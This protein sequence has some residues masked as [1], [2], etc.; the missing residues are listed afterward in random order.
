MPKHHNII[1]VGAGLSGLYTAWKLQQT[2]QDVIVLEARSRSG[3]RIFSVE[4]GDSQFDLGPAWV[5]PQMQLR[6][7]QLITELKLEVFKQFT[8][9]DMLY[10]KNITQVERYAAQSSHSESYRV[11]G[12]NQLLTSAIK[13][14]L[15]ASSLCL[16][17]RVTSINSEDIHV[18]VLQNNK[19]AVYTANRVI[20][21]LPP[22]VFQQDIT[23]TPE[24]SDATTALWKNTPTWM[25]THSKIIFIYDKPFWRE[26]N[27]SGEVFSHVGPLA[28]IYDASP[29][30][31]KLY[32]LSAFVGLNPHQRKH[33]DNDQ[34]IASCLA[35]LKRVFGEA[36]QPP[37]EIQLKD[38]SSEEFTC[39]KIDIES[40]IQHPQYSR[41][42]PREFWD[43]KLLLAGTEVALEYGGYLEGALES[44]DRAISICA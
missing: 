23:F 15:P 20:L 13:R 5:W 38:W 21:A 44:A 3:G 34:L 4:C 10:E 14:R 12:G 11:R 26:Q 19:P 7:H 18:E 35:Q 39:A 41:D 33:I 22:R 29:G 37:L 30:D 17:T 8:Q 2:K 6:V 36:S 25:A 16:N 43:N 9:G 40:P 28:E 1:I 32:A 31:G 24:F 27:L 42:S